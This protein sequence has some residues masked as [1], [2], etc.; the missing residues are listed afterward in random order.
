MRITRIAPKEVMITI[1][2]SLTESEAILNALDVA[3]IIFPDN[4]VNNVEA[5]KAIKEFFNL[6]NEAVKAAKGG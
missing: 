5:D 1:E 6:V 4:S 2:M 3:E